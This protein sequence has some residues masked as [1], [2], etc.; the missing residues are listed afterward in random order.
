[1]IMQ[2]PDELWCHIF[3]F[4]P[5]IVLHKTVSLVCKYWLA[6]VR[7]DTRHIRL[8]CT[9][10]NSY[11][12]LKYNGWPPVQ[13]RKLDTLLSNY[14][15][16]WPKL[17]SIDIHWICEKFKEHDLFDTSLDDF[18]MIWNVPLVK[19]ISIDIIVQKPPISAYEVKFKSNSICFPSCRFIENVHSQTWREN[20]RWWSEKLDRVEM[21]EFSFGMYGPHGHGQL[22][23]LAQNPEAVLF[24][25]KILTN[26]IDNIKRLIIG[27]C[28]KTCNLDP[29]L[30]PL[31]KRRNVKLKNL[32]LRY[33]HGRQ[34]L[35]RS[36]QVLQSLQ[37]L[38]HLEISQAAFRLEDFLLMGKTFHGLKVFHVECGDPFWD[39]YEDEFTYLSVFQL[40]EFLTT[41]QSMKTLIDFRI[42][43]L[44]PMDRNS[45]HQEYSENCSFPKK[46]KTAQENFKKDAELQL[47]PILKEEFSANCFV[48]IVFLNIHHLKMFENDVY[49][50]NIPY[51]HRNMNCLLL[52]KDKG[53]IELDLIKYYIFPMP[54][55]FVYSE[56]LYVSKPKRR[57]MK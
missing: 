41:F 11:F 21:E 30:K 51:E 33:H 40:K 32:C 50:D 6:L 42:T 39:G 19:S 5:P 52:V 16:I 46:C 14:L 31:L 23:I 28:E 4:L 45:N 57:R 24:V 47:I 55:H 35:S 36:I 26:N 43:N 3:K 56:C 44:C 49:K 53:N 2:L 9:F 18:K 1:M 37:N 29:F 10:L 17:Q 54:E 34:G 48:L 27:D 15:K 20:L 8:R 38:T 12:E 25:D 13:R 7:N 22:S